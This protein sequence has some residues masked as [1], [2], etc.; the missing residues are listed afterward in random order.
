MRKYL[1]ALLFGLM[2]NPASA[3]A[4]GQ[5]QPPASALSTATAPAPEVGR[6]VAPP[7]VPAP[8]VPPIPP[9]FT[10]GD[11]PPLPARPFSITKLDPA[12]DAIVA[13]NAKLDL[14]DDHFGLTEGPV[15]VPEGKS[16]YLLF[17]DMLSNVIWK[18]TPDKKVSVFLYSAGYS[19][20][21][22]L[23]AGIQSRRGR[24]NVLLIGPECTTRDSQGRILWCASND[25]AI[26]RL[27]KDNTRTVLAN[28]IDGK[29]FNGPND[30]TMKSDGAI[31]FADTETGLRDGKLSP[32]RQIPYGG[33]YLVK[34]DKVTLLLDEK[35]LGG[36]PNGIALSPDEKYL[37]LSA[38]TSKIM[39]YPLKSDDTLGEGTLFA[40]GPGIGDGIKVDKLGNVY[41]TGGAGPGEVLIVS[42][43][44][45]RL[46]LLNIPLF[47]GEPK[48]EICALNVAF[49]DPDGKGLYIMA[50]EAVFK[51]RLKVAGI[52]P[53]PQG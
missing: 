10:L 22:L 9:P 44:G 24:A 11:G 21:D 13:P 7:A 46:G 47:D 18:M 32:L 4:P 20:K 29:R 36:G 19:G 14:L 28:N 6:V 30:M 50:G 53:G 45:K 34:D 23:H 8:P 1:T 48:R 2:A 25:G 27:E 40:E 42:A 49:G 43:E 51:I 35:A 15:W 17:V 39:R 26:M 52:I 16:G 41:S 33:I 12:L 37:Y 5:A 38:G 31:F 3:Q